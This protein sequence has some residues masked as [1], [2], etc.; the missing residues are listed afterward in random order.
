METNEIQPGSTSHDNVAERS[1]IGQLIMHPD[2]LY[3]VR[4]RLRSDS[5]YSPKHQVIFASLCAMNTAG[6]PIDLVTVSSYMQDARTLPSAGGQ[7]YLGEVFIEYAG[8]VG[9]CVDRVLECATTRAAYAA[10]VRLEQNLAQPGTALEA[11]AAAHAELE[12]IAMGNTTVARTIEDVDA[13]ASQFARLNGPAP[14]TIS[15]GLVDLDDALKHGWHDGQLILLAARM[16]VGKTAALGGFAIHAS[17]GEG[18]RGLFVSIEMPES[19]LVKRMTAARLSIPLDR[20]NAGK[21]PVDGLTPGDWDKLEADNAKW[22]AAGGCPGGG[23]IVFMTE[24]SHRDITI[25]LIISEA[26]RLNRERKLHYIVIDYLTKIEPSRSSREISRSREVGVISTRLA[27]LAKDLWIPVIVAAQLN[28]DGAGGVPQIKHLADSD[29]PARDADVVLLLSDPVKDGDSGR[30]GE[31]DIIVEKNRNGTP[32]VT[33][34]VASLMHF[35][36]LDGLAQEY[37]GLSAA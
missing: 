9:Y 31:L 37:G 1:L 6:T 12:T 24:E 13:N 26:Q 18:K 33:V 2:N 8:D 25:D 35:Q 28:R 5:F 19:T 36:R 22:G 4:G 14:T 29:V 32:G 11:I 34:P 17:Y 10:A 30:V 16:S 21:D 23:S 20:L 3:E 27:K 15:T 7:A